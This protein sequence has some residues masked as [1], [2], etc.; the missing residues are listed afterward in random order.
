MERRSS[1]KNTSITPALGRFLLSGLMG[2][3]L[4]ASP[5]AADVRD[6]AYFF[7]RNSGNLRQEAATARWE[8]KRG[9]LIMFDQANCPACTTLMTTVLSHAAT[10]DFYRKYFRIL[11]VDIKS[12]A[13]YTDFVGKPITAKGFAAKYRIETAPAFMFFDLNGNQ[14]LKYTGASHDPGEFIWLGEFVVQGDYKSKTFTAYK[15]EKTHKK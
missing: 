14:R 6:P 13:D 4:S 2:L 9:V 11:R 7:D 12:A 1:L 10:Q 3:F 5:R 8:G 15:F